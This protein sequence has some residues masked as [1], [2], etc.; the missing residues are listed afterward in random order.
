MT[1]LK[2]DLK[3]KKLLDALDRNP[4]NTLSQLG[5]EIRES[6]QVVEYRINRLLKQKTIYGFF[7][8]IDLGM[9]GYTLFRVHIKLK[10][11]SEEAYPQ[12]AKHLFEEYPT[13]WVAFVSG[14]FDIIADLW[15]KNSNKFETL[16]SQVLQK[17]K[18]F[19]YSYEIN[20]ILELDLYDYGYFLLEQTERKK[21]PLFRVL[22]A[23]SIDK[24]D[25]EI[26]SVIKSDARISYQGINKK[27]GLSRNA[28]KYRIKNLEKLGV[29]AGYK[30]MVDF[31]HFDRL[32]Y[33]IF[34]KYDNSK[35]DQEKTL[36]GYLQ[37]I[38]AVL[39]TTKH[40]GRWNLDIEFEPRN[41][42]E[43]QKFI[44][45]L[46]NKFS[47]IEAYEFIQILEDYGLDFYPKKLV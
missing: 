2:L 20:P 46:R 14:S 7:T 19:I 13:F 21:V 26:L 4:T 45:N 39:S 38:P 22:E 37:R 44:I 18:D 40:L 35:I 15:A 6:P 3:D 41:A 25:K 24:K 34:I 12:F 47:L 28:V 30:I 36:L 33:K 29:I 5:K 9:L 42:S 27:V 32:T 31:K 43:L 23:V 8:L 1:K 17:N 16:F 11:V 10:S